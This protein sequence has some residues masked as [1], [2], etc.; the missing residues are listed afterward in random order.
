MSE[1]DYAVVENT[2]AKDDQLPIVACIR[3]Q[4]VMGYYGKTELFFGRPEV[5]GCLPEYRN[6]GLIRRLFLEMIHPASDAR[7]D[8]IQVIPGIQYFYRQFGYEYGLTL[9][10][11]R[12]IDNVYTTLPE[13]DTDK[14]LESTDKNHSSFTLRSPTLKDIPF[15]IRM[16][17]PEKLYNQAQTGLLYDEKYWRYTIHDLIETAESKYD[18][19]RESRIIVDSK[20]GRDCGVVVT[21]S[22]AVYDMPILAFLI[23]SLEDGYHYRDALFPVMRQMVEIANRPTL[24]ELQE[25]DK[26]STDDNKNK[27][28]GEQQEQ[29]VKTPKP[30]KIQSLNL[31]LD[32]NHPV[33][34]LLESKSVIASR[35]LKLYIRIL[36]Y[37]K[38][39]LKIAP[40]LE[41]R[42]EKSH[43]A[44]IT[45]TL[46]LNFFKKVLGSSGKGLEIVF[47]NGKII[48][49]SDDWVLLSPEEKHSLALKRIAERAQQDDSSSKDV[50]TPKKKPLVYSADFAPLTFTKLLLGDLSIDQM[51]DFYGE[52]KTSDEQDVEALFNIL[53]PKEQAHFDMFWW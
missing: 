39:I 29:E 26:N 16:S 2:L 36:S 46:Q 8:V 23:F 43:L 11:S 20:T 45:V 1:Y 19:L 42:L 50:E 9:R 44:G 32:S 51:L 40:T 25:S 4:G 33:M 38:F 14:P 41:E 48:S 24:W 49:A 22:L 5:V 35:R 21:K 53:F 15:L 30:K 28:E 37:A 52:C 27:K 7:G 10:S 18:S 3:L 13:L 47:E 6:K 12:K 31:N 34:K 17:T